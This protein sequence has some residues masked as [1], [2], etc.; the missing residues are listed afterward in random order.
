MTAKAAKSWNKECRKYA[1]EN[2]RTVGKWPK[3]GKKKAQAGRRSKVRRPKAQKGKAREP[4]P[5]DAEV[6]E[7]E[8]S[9]TAMQ[10]LVAAR[11][12]RRRPE[13]DG[14][15]NPA[16]K[17]RKGGKAGK[18]A[19]LFFPCLAIGERVKRGKKDRTK[20]ARDEET[21]QTEEPARSGALKRGLGTTALRQRM[22]ARKAK[23]PSAEV[24]PDTNARAAVGGQAPDPQG[25]TAG[26]EGQTHVEDETTP[27]TSKRGR[28][29]AIPAGVAAAI[30]GIFKKRGQGNSKATE[31]DRTSGAKKNGRFSALRQ[32]IRSLRSRVTKKRR[33][34]DSEDSS[35]E[36]RQKT[37]KQK[38][39]TP[40]KE[41]ARERQP[42]STKEHGAIVGLAAG[43]I[44]LPGVKFKEARDRRRKDNTES[45]TAAPDAASPVTS[46]VAS[47]IFAG[48]SAAAEGRGTT[49][50]LSTGGDRPY[51]QP[52]TVEQQLNEMGTSRPGLTQYL[53]GHGQSEIP[54]HEPDRPRP[55][56]RLGSADTAV[57]ET[58]TSVEPEN[59][60]QPDSATAATKFKSL[61]DG[62]G[63][64]TTRKRGTGGETAATAADGGNTASTAGE[65]VP[66]GRLPI[67][68]GG[69]GNLNKSSK[70]R[71]AG[72]QRPHTTA[73][74]GSLMRTAPEGGPTPGESGG[75]F[76]GIKGGLGNIRG[77]KNEGEE[78]KSKE[79]PYKDKEPGLIE[80]IRWILYV[81]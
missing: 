79:K 3:P 13:K 60:T 40:T 12:N 59:H 23:K 66:G 45:A 27:K 31:K 48:P 76:K 16:E 49:R 7:D 73:P 14:D 47:T 57:E 71:G 64:L 58:P 18:V 63:H 68:K 44:A 17:K 53:P 34:A 37:K 1:K 29:L 11:K 50:S 32:Y 30:A 22:E 46:P 77:R 65:S 72:A 20:A 15:A 25:Q 56:T 33:P 75:K 19:I 2:R 62:L 35:R 78:P 51:Y 52:P 80:R 26:V 61:R 21:A 6:T 43:V 42:R 55:E 39:T 70:R 10:R 38:E 67:I 81:A 24:Q 4:D 5:A 41:T 28:L 69:F 9:A 8:H 36:R 54:M 74:D